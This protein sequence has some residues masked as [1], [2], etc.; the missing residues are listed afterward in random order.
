MDLARKYPRLFAFF[1][2]L[3]GAGAL[4]LGAEGL[5]RLWY[6][7][8][9][10][11]TPVTVE[12]S[13]GL[14]DHLQLGWAPKPSRQGMWKLS[15][16]DQLIYE[17]TYTT[18]QYGRRFTPVKNPQKSSLKTFQKSSM[19]QYAIFMGASFAFGEGVQDDETLPAQFG[20]LLSEYHPYN[21]GVMGYGPHQ[22]LMQLKLG[23]GGKLRSQVKESQGIGIYVFTNDHIQ[24]A[25]GSM[26][27]LN[28]VERSPYFFINKDGKLEQKENFSAGRPGLNKIYSFL[29]EMKLIKLL[30]LDF[31]PL[32]MGNH[33]ELTAKLFEQ[34]K[35]LYEK[36]FGNDRF[37]V[38][39]YP[40]F[41]KEKEKLIPYL[42]SKKINYLDFPE[43]K[44]GP[45]HFI[46]VS[47][48]PTSQAYSILA[49]HLAEAVKK[50]EQRQKP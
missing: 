37:Y 10:L 26:K 31:P 11:P 4:L 16:G 7:I 1:C 39:F 17:V 50:L 48:H 42:V 19:Q 33:Y 44:F 27:M 23:Q 13:Y 15:K 6:F 47:R 28:L 25:I 8:R 46:P 41:S 38:L 21:Y 35:G 36:E 18:D 49:E 45:E 9:P 34:I 32:L 24:R 30:D 14:P 3:M 20:K 12:H 5:A 2:G 22:T 40:G 43:I 29:K